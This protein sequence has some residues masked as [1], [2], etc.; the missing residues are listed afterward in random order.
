MAEENSNVPPSGTPNPPKVSI[1]IPVQ[2]KKDS[3]S[4]PVTP[5]VEAVPKVADSIKVTPKKETVRITLPPK[6][7]S[8]PTVKI[9]APA[10]AAP[11]A[12][13]APVAGH[14]A[15]P[16]PPSAV[17]PVSGGATPPPPNLRK[18]TAAPAKVDKLDIGLAVTA[19]VAGIAALVRVFMLGGE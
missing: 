12:T 9:P 10:A 8:A 19:A 7:T 2:A 3:G 18:P 1:G 15:P 14:A 6:P 16:L 17:P 11:T 4:I 5:K 13:A